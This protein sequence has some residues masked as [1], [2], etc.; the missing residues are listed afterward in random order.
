M[1]NSFIYCVNVSDILSD[2]TLNG[3]K[4]YLASHPLDIVIP[5]ETPIE[6]PLTPQTL[7]TLKGTNSI[8]SDANGPIEITYWTH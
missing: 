1:Q 4:A 3:W 7:K 8:W 2:N 5:L 6:Y